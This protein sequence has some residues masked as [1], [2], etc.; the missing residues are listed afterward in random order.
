MQI[1]IWDLTSPTS[2]FS[3][4]SRSRSL[5]T[6]TSL[7]WN[8]SVVHILASSSNSGMT[9]VWDLK[10]KREITAL[11]FAGGGATGLGPGGFGAG[12]GGAGVQGLGA[13]GFGGPAGA[14]GGLG[15][16]GGHSAVKWHPENVR[17]CGV[18]FPSCRGADK[19]LSDVLF[20]PAAHQARHGE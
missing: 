3:P 15:G 14:Q 18:A 5:D 7:A 4:G 6:I 10:S 11:S 9:V 19:S 20:T 1:F 2:P 16:L 17:R 8:P 12:G 13:G